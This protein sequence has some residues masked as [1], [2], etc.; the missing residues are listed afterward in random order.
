M[1]LHNFF[2][3]Q[4]QQ[5]CKPVQRNISI[6]DTVPGFKRKALSEAIAQVHA[7]QADALRQGMIGL[8]KMAVH[9]DDA[10]KLAE[11]VRGAKLWQVL[12]KGGKVGVVTTGVMTAASLLL[13]KEA[14]A[15]Q[16]DLADMY[17]TDGHL[18]PA[19][20]AQ[21]KGIMDDMAEFAII[22]IRPYNQGHL[23]A[24]AWHGV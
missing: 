8:E 15:A 6:P 13:T 22:A 3:K 10:A 21:Y 19:Q 11:T 18:T 17:R 4:K 12:A 1:Y 7:P 16:R 2:L 24:G 20:H 23:S 14:V 5:N 9:S